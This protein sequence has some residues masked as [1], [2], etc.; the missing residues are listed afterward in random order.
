METMITISVGTIITS[1]VTAVGIFWAVVLGVLQLQAT[2]HARKQEQGEKSAGEVAN[3][4][5][6]E[7]FCRLSVENAERELN[8]VKS[9]GE[10]TDMHL[11]LHYSRM[12]EAIKSAHESNDWTPVLS[13][14]NEVKDKLKEARTKA[15]SGE[16][17]V[18]DA[19]RVARKEWE[20]SRFK[21]NCR[22]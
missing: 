11:K 18:Q 10:V 13:A 14:Y 6:R 1:V 8:A 21:V 16:D 7:H 22:V 9:L 17:K 15:S 12:G 20:E 4:R 3:D 19:L 5:A 2:H